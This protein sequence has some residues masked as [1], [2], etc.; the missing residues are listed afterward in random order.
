MAPLR[1]RELLREGAFEE[2]PWSREEERLSLDWDVTLVCC[3]LV[4]ELALT[5]WRP[6]VTSPV[7]LR[8]KS[9]SSRGPREELREPLRIW[10]RAIRASSSSWRLRSTT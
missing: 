6:G 2:G 5:S 9:W 1:L 4:R 8:G 10:L 7:E 3:E